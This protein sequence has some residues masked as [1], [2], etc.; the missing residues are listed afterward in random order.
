MRVGVIGIN[1][2]IADLKLRELLAKACQKRFSFNRFNLLH[3]HY[4]ILLST[5]NRTEIY[6]YSEDLATA[7]TYLL[8]ILRQEVNED[9]DQKLYSY[10]GQDCFLHLSRVT[11]GL[12]S[13][14]IAETEIQGQVK[15]TYENA[16]NSFRLPEELH[17]LFQKSLKIGKNVRSSLPISR[18]LPNLAHSVFNKGSEFFGSLAG[19][20]ILFVGASEINQKIISYFKTKKI[21]DISICNRSP[22]KALC[23]A[24]QFDVKFFDWDSLKNWHN[25]DFIIFGTRSPGF[26]LNKQQISHQISNKLVIDLCVPRNVDPSLAE[27]PKITVINIDQL[28]DSLVIKKEHVLHCLQK[29]EQHV[30]KS[31]KQQMELFQQKVQLREKFLVAS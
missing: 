6:F 1:H 21:S 10:F 25:F 3:E 26:L 5:C 7:H 8:N 16:T 11:A 19:S 17:Y 22:Q 27:N 29:A 30:Q 23:F 18:G 13:A 15:S 20:S 4:F 2:K 14:I 31:A 12:D 28:N 9:F 24:A